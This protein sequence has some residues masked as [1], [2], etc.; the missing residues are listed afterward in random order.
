MKASASARSTGPGAAIDAMDSDE[1]GY[2]PLCCCGDGPGPSRFSGTTT[3]FA[4]W[5][6]VPSS[7][8]SMVSTVALCPSM[9]PAGTSAFRHSA[10]A[11]SAM[12]KARCRIR[13]ERTRVIAGA[14]NLATPPVINAYQKPTSSARRHPWTS[15]IG[16]KTRGHR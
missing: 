13:K 15:S 2:S 1:N 12:A 6:P 4:A 10:A 8:T 9:Y 14:H 7:H 16:T 5:L 11:T 3:S